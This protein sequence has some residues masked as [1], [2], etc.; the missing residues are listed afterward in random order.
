M[1]QIVT[2]SRPSRDPRHLWSLLRA[3]VEAVH[4]G[5]GVERIEVR[6]AATGR[7]RHWQMTGVGGG[8]GAAAPSDDEAGD[9]DRSLG[10]L[11]D[12]LSERLGPN[13]AVRVVPVESH[14]PERSFARQPAM[15]IGRARGTAG[16]EAAVT[17]SDRPSR[18]FARPE[19][20]EVMAMTPDG[21]P[22]WLHW[23]GEARRIITSFGPERIGGEWW[24][25][26][27]QRHKG[28]EA[29][30]GGVDREATPCLRASVPP[31]LPHRDYFKVQDERGRWL[32]VYRESTRGRWFVHGEWG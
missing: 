7:L 9:I 8:S 27:A 25:Q 13:R 19:R 12:T 15:E 18:L 26:Q 24:G 16:G 14:V 3:K 5:Y 11:L 23:R 17:P 20:V 10:E 22:S 1:R 6:A 28:T 4:L 31:S 21:P 29:R 32:W 2:L 30:R